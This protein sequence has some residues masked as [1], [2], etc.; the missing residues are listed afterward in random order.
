M[1]QVFLHG[2]LDR[3]EKNV[4]PE[5]PTDDVPNGFYFQM[6]NKLNH[7]VYSIPSGLSVISRAK[8]EASVSF[9]DSGKTF[10]MLHETIKTGVCHT[11]LLFLQTVSTLFSWSGKL[12]LVW[13]CVRANKCFGKACFCGHRH[14]NKRFKVSFIELSL[15][16][17]SRRN[18]PPKDPLIYCVCVWFLS[19]YSFSTIL[20]SSNREVCQ[21]SCFIHQCDR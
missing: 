6:K 12:L 4:L 10:T 7:I 17:L 18:F 11:H 5:Y 9:L 8:M 3:I 15:S 1:K 14:L 20:G 2:L 13:V 19:S 16:V 21:H